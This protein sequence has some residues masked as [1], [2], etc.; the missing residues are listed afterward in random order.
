MGSRWNYWN[1]WR[2]ILDSRGN[3]TVEVEVTADKTM[4]K[5]TTGTNPRH[6]EPVRQAIEL[7]DGEE[8]YL[9]LEHRRGPIL[10]D[11]AVNI[12]YLWDTVSHCK[13][14][15]KI[16][17]PVL[18]K[19]RK[20]HSSRL[21]IPERCYQA[22]HQRERKQECNNQS[23]SKTEPP[24][25]DLWERN[26]SRIRT[27]GRDDKSGSPERHDWVDKKAIN[28]FKIKLFLHELFLR[29]FVLP[30]LFSVFFT[31]C[32]GKTKSLRMSS[33]GMILI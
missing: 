3:P 9:G 15:K 30:S 13:C 19:R 31:G 32:K 12:S 23:L 6:P 27:I 17:C 11:L 24:V 26:F 8:R 1:S 29:D 4:E 28:W 18:I 22:A 10:H 7:A 25:S 33:S 16:K 21:L 14:A 5:K 20:R 2:E